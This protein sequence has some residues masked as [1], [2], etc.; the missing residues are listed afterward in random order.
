MNLA[1]INLIVA[2]L[3]SFNSKSDTDNHTNNNIL[4]GYHKTITL[5]SI[6]LTNYPGIIAIVNDIFSERDSVNK[7]TAKYY[8]IQ[9]TK[10]E[11]GEFAYIIESTEDYL[12]DNNNYIGYAF[13]GDDNDLIILAG[14][15]GKSIKKNYGKQ[16]KTF[17][18]ENDTPMV[19]DPRVWDYYVDQSVYARYIWNIGWFWH[20][21]TGYEIKSKDSSIITFPKRNKK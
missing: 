14:E 6:K 5:P 15:E 2:I 8:L 17:Y 9:L 18:L 20:V 21:P 7:N 4:Q 19:Y 16:T 1:I 11:K 10:H 12:P 3:A 13:W